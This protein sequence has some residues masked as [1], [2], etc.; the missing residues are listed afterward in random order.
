METGSFY[1]AAFD[2]AQNSRLLPVRY[3]NQYFLFRTHSPQQEYQTQEMDDTK[4]DLNEQSKQRNHEAM[5][6]NNNND[7]VKGGGSSGDS[8][9][10]NFGKDEVSKKF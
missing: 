7:R 4:W 9:I 10:E 8:T 5:Q 1:R 6:T 2:R 3:P